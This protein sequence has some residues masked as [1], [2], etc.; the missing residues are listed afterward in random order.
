MD[1]ST[2]MSRKAQSPVAIVLS[3]LATDFL[4]FGTFSAMPAFF[5]SCGKGTERV[6]ADELREVLGATVS[7]IGLL[8]AHL[9]AF[10]ARRHRPRV[11]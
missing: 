4:N 9:P 1:R 6:V 7:S 2:A 10:N 8:V 5:A 3:R 11:F